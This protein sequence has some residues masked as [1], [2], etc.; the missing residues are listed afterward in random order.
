MLEPKNPQNISLKAD[1]GILLG[2]TKSATDPIYFVSF[3]FSVKTKKR[4]IKVTP[5]SSNFPEEA[6][7]MESYTARSSRERLRA[8]ETE[9]DNDNT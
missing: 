3:F 8:W 5:A 2:R 7:I 9:V 6:V 4:N 1:C